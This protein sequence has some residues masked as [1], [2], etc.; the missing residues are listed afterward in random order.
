MNPDGKVALVTGAGSGLGRATA[1]RLA[2][3]GATVA[4]LDRSRAH[5]ETVAGPWGDSMLVAPVDVTDAD[6]IET[7]V[8]RITEAFGALHI[9][10][11]CAGIGD[12]AR[13][14][15]RSGPAPLVHFERVLAVNLLGTLNVT[16]LAVAAML[17]NPG[18]DERGVV[19]NTASGAAFDGQVGQVA[20]AASKA[21]I[22]G[23]TLPAARDL[24][25]HGIRVNAIAPGLF[26]TA[27]L[28]GLDGGVLRELTKSVVEPSRLG[29]PEEFA[30][31]VVHI[32]ENSYLNGT[33]VR[34]DG[35]ARLPAH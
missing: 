25:G 4:V 22:V 23:M 12:A 33:C 15:S 24:A 9:C 17:E 14:V 7:A 6:A 27:L 13:I 20:Y 10:V 18:G 8:A 34:L 29:R 30:S 2:G 32:V 11:N 1:E 26:D 35:A 19:V 31:L 5:L 16:R 3:L 21:G 28:A